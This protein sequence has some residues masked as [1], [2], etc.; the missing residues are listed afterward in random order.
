MI[1]RRRRGSD[2]RSIYLIVSARGREQLAKISSRR[3]DLLG[4]IFL[5]LSSRTQ[6]Q[7][8]EALPAFIEAAGDL[9]VDEWS[10]RG[11]VASRV[12]AADWVQ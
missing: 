4:A 11:L 10:I 3:G 2:R 7:L 1:S 5:K 8:A 9:D 12:T 6:V